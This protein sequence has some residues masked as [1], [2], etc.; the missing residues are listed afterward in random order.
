[1]N[2]ITT[3]E[4]VGIDAEGTP[5]IWDRARGIETARKSDLWG[6]RGIVLPARY[7]RTQADV[8]RH[9]A[10]LTANIPPAIYCASFNPTVGNV[11][12]SC[13]VVVDHEGDFCVEHEDFR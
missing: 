12:G 2:V 7:E 4:V 6:P 10:A 11:F 5:I 13:G 1:M 8:D 3:T 9:W